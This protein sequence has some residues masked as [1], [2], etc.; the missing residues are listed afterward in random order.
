MKIV[1]IGAGNLG[2]HVGRQLAKLPKVEL[3]QIY[4]RTRKKAQALAKETGSTFTT[5]L[6][7]LKS[8]DVYLIAVSDDA[9]A[10]VAAQ[11]HPKNLA[12]NPL[13]AHTSGATPRT[14][15]AP[16]STRTGIFY[17]PQT[18]SKQKNPDW[19]ATP[20]LVD[21]AQEKDLNSLTQL[22]Q[23]FT[24]KVHQVTDEQ[25]LQLHVAAVFVN[26]FTN[27]LYGIGHELMAQAKL[28]F[29]ILLPLIEATVQKLAAFEPREVQTGPAVRGDEAT[30]QRHLDLLKNNETYQTIYRQMSEGII[31]AK[32]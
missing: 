32:K 15:L 12:K 24:S 25:R 17:P 6:K 7:S 27:Y 21:A 20:I 10:Q 1:L 14:V 30:M 4:S 16:F 22:A 23:Q 5:S 26:N 11:I 18:F 31:A 2:W 28:D 19:A 3:V 8:A 13:L 9:I 29:Q